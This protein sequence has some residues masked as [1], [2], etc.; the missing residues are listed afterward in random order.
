VAW[1][2]KVFYLTGKYEDALTAF[3][4]AIEIK[5]KVAGYWYYK[6]LALKS[7]HQDAEAEAALSKAKEL[8]YKAPST[9]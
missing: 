8:G 6:S 2:G 1:N 9:K 7:L 4:K 5:P 3:N